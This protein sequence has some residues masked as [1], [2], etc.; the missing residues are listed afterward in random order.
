MKSARPSDRGFRLR[1]GGI[2]L[3]VRSGRAGP[4]LRVP[5]IHAPFLT[6]RGGTIRLNAVDAPVPDPSRRDLVFESGGPWRVFVF[7]GGLL[8]QCRSAANAPRLFQGF[9]VDAT[10]SHGTLYA[11]QGPMAP[12]FTLSYPLD[13]L[14]FAHRLA[15]DGHALLHACGV[16]AGRSAF[17]LCGRS[18]AG[19][20]TSARLWSRSRLRARVLSDDR[21]VIRR[22]ARGPRIFG[23]PWQGE[24]RFSLAAS[25]PLTAVFFLRH[26]GKTRAIPISASDAAGRLYARSFP[27]VW[28]SQGVGGVI[29]CCNEI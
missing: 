13:E 25:R 27:P 5:A 8:Y 14:L 19:K 1:V 2:V 28:D 12:R 10:F 21:I 6:A 20:S 24:A 4:A 15:R 7:E 16:V 9:A 18:G 22:G 3:V 17:L 11:P 23:T 29:E 26:A